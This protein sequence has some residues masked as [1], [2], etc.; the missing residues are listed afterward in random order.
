MG[1]FLE[2]FLVPV[3]EGIVAAAPFLITHNRFHSAGIHDFEYIP[4]TFNGTGINIP[5]NNIEIWAAAHKKED[6]TFVYCFSILNP[7][8][9]VLGYVLCLDRRDGLEHAIMCR[10]T[11]KA[12]A[13]CLAT[14]KPDKFGE[15]DV[16]SAPDT[17]LRTGQAVPYCVVRRLF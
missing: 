15:I 17:A 14:D 8:I 12:G 6:I 11:V 7:E 10:N 5:E 3:P 2:F 13:V 1:Q 16:G 9:A 4:G